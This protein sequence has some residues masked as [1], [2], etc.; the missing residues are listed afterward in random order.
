[1]KRMHGSNTSFVFD[2]SIFLRPAAM[3]IFCVFS[4]ILS[5]C[6]LSSDDPCIRESE[7]LVEDTDAAASDLDVPKNSYSDLSIPTEIIKIQDTYYIVDCYHDQVIYNDNLRDPLEDWNVLTSEMSRGHTIAG[8]GRVYLVDDTENERIMVFQRAGDKYVFSQEFTGITGRPHYII[9]D[10]DSRTFYVWCSVSGQMYL[11]K[12]R[13]DD[14]VFISAVKTVPE[15]AG[16]YVRS[17]TIMDGDIYFVSGNCSI[18]QA[19]LDSFD[20]KERYP[21][22]DTMAGMVQITRIDGEYYITVS[23]DVNWDQDYATIIRCVSLK[24]LAEGRYEDIYSNFIGGG[25]PYYITSFD[26]AYFMTEHRIPGHSIWRFNVRD[27]QIEADT[28]Y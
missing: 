10:E 14:R 4:F 25:T 26:G 28:L 6:S 1:M 21:V 23:T 3:L 17:F 13:D 7:V 2:G 22:P 18:I 15:L 11:M 16:V 19:D 24:D 8:D 27:G 12:R 5:S 20:V 9:Y